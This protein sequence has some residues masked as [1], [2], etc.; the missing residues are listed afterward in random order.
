MKVSLIVAAA[1]ND[2]IGRDNDLPWDLPEDRKRFK[3]LTNGH[4]LVSGR[5]NQDSIVSRLGRPLPGRITVVVTRQLRPNDGSVLYQDSVIEALR[6]ARSIEDFA[7]RDEVFV[8][9]GA[10]IYALALP[11]VDRV[12]LT[13]VHESVEG[14]VVMP[15]GWLDGFELVAREP[16][17]GYTYEQYERPS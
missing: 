12:Y 1:E 6:L 15:E 7:G 2:V 3:R 8:I 17:A 4:A 9:G 10:E 11:E 13:R 14:D 16:Q 5:R